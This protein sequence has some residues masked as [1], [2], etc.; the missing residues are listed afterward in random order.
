MNAAVNDFGFNE[1]PP[2]RTDACA[3][4]GDYT[5]RNLFR[6]MWTK[7]PKCAEEARLK[8]EEAEQE[9]ERLAEIARWEARLGSAGIPERFRNRTLETYRADSEGQRAALKFAQDYADHFAENATTG[10]SAL[11]IGKPG[12]GKTHLAVGIGLAGM[13]Q[14]YAVLFTTAM[15]ALRRVK[16]TWSRNSEESERD[17]IAALVYP[18]L[19][20]LDEVGIQFGSDTEKLILFDVLNERY[21]QRK[22]TLL[23]SNLTLPEVREYLGER[24]FDRLR[25]DGG[26]VLVF[27]WQS[28]RGIDRKTAAAGGDA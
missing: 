10:K 2:E 22:P 21:E 8:A 12:T 20:I 17:A 26:Q 5:A 13:E 1:N 28:H 23:L 24:I 4:H 19:L 9:K 16:E 14:G 6:T 3:E 27:D 18:H 15:R 11:F 7:C 25:E